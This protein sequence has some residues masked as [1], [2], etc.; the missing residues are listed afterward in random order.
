MAGPGSVLA[1]E[2][3]GGFPAAAAVAQG[4]KVATHAV[5]LGGVDTLVQHPAALTHRP[6]AASARPDESVLRISVGLEDPEDLL[7]DLRAALDACAAP[8]AGHRMPA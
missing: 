8:S 2:L 1:V 5:S 3:A 4:L 6:V 7:A